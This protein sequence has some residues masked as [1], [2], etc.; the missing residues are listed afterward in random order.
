M[1]SDRIGRKPVIAGG[2]FVFALG[3]VVAAMADSVDGVILG[4]AL[5]GAERD[6][7]SAV[8]VTFDPRPAVVLRPD[9]APVMLTPLEQKLELLD[10]VKWDM[11][12]EWS[13]TK[14]APRHAAWMHADEFMKQDQ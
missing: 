9:R 14:K 11:L 13:R 5:Q 10:G 3:S 1:L 8:V 12:E 2:L 4:R 6:G 7:G